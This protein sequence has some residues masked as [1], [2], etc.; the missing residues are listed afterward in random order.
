MFK[1][2]NQTEW[3]DCMRASIA[4]VMQWEPSELPNFADFDDWQ[5]MIEDE[6]ES[7]GY[8]WKYFIDSEDHDTLEHINESPTGWLMVAVP[9]INYDSGTH[10]IVV[11]N[12]FSFVHDPSNNNRYTALNKEDIVIAYI[13]LKDKQ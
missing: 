8:R 9:S 11:D 3:N 6:F 1:K 2:H 10:A 12:N 4:T 5:E 13:V 7:R